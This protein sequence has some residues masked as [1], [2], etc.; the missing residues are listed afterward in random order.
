MLSFVNKEAPMVTRRSS[1][2]LGVVQAGL[3]VLSAASFL[4]FAGWMLGYNG[5]GLVSGQAMPRQLSESN[6]AVYEP[7]HVLGA[8]GV[9]TAEAG[10][11]ITGGVPNG[12][13]RAGDGASEFFGDD[14]SL[15]FWAATHSQHAAWV[16]VR[17]VPPLGLAGIWWLL[18]LIVR[19]VRNR[20]GYTRSV[21]RRIRVIGALVLVGIPLL[22]LCRWEV[23]RW[24]V[25]SSSAAKIAAVGD[26]RLELWPLAVG[27]VI[28]V[29][30]SAWTEAARMREDLEGLV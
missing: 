19:S 30:A 13:I 20:A 28:L 15:T 14:A 10:N 9:A 1:V 18:F 7:V 8:A 17:A 26:F 21:A 12:E 24:L 25:E 4:V 29:M 16:A 23:A 27:L 3:L 11:H 22:Q 5:V 6:A 2:V